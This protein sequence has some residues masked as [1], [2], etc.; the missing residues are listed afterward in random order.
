MAL[1]TLKDPIG[2]SLG[3]LGYYAYETLGDFEA[4]IAGYQGD[5]PQFTMWRSRCDVL[6]EKIEED[7]FSYDCD[8]YQGSSGSAVYA[9]DNRA[10]QRVIVGVNVASGPEIMNQ[11][12]RLNQA[13]YEWINSLNK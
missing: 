1:I 9:Y 2:D 13:N 10:K 5:K 4:N 8:V 11:A 3:W 7:V 12:V 6:T